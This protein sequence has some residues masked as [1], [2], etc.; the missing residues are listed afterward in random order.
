MT[1]FVEKILD[2]SLKR[3]YHC[4]QVAIT[5]EKA[6][7]YSNALKSSDVSWYLDILT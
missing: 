7:V 2:L 3:L 4:F 1:I 6:Q 5:I